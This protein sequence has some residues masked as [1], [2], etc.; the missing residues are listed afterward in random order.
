MVSLHKN[1]IHN[2]QF[3]SLEMS[4]NIKPMKSHFD[5][6]NL[7]PDPNRAA[8]EL[9]RYRTCCK[10]TA[11]RVKYTLTHICACLDNALQKCLWFLAGVL[12]IFRHTIANA[13]D[14]PDISRS[15]R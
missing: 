10:Y 12:F 7:T 2:A 14:I 6:F 3:F 4:C 15:F 9:S 8:T 1:F 13:R 5:V 11:K